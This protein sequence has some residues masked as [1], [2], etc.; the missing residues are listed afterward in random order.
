M[1]PSS[2][3][4]RNKG[5]KGRNGLRKKKVSKI[6]RLKFLSVR[7]YETRFLRDRDLLTPKNEENKSFPRLSPQILP[8]PCPSP[9]IPSI[10]FSLSTFPHRP[11]SL[12]CT[13]PFTLSFQS[14]P[15]SSLPLNLPLACI[16]HP[17][18]HPPFSSLLSPSL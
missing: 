10:P 17:A 3:G 14:C 9:Q 12:L 4:R 8:S 2:G 18:S 11:L 1:L 6:R 5:G 16:P 13:F 15:H 7:G